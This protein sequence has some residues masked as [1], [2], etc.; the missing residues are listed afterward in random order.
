MQSGW[1]AV[2][3]ACENGPLDIVRVL[4]DKQVNVNHRNKVWLILYYIYIQ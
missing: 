2:M 3:I 1:T 4:V